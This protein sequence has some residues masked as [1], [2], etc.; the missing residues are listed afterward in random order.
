MF[1]DFF[2]TINVFESGRVSELSNQEKKSY[3]F[4][5]ENILREKKT[6]YTKTREALQ[7]RILGHF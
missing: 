3:Q 4:K 2:K 6:I 1:S 7:N 5:I